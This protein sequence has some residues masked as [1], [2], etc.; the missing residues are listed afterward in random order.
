MWILPD[1]WRAATPSVLCLGSNHF[2]QQSKGLEDGSRSHAGVKATRPGRCSRAGHA[3]AP[4]PWRT[5]KLKLKTRRL[6]RCARFDRLRVP[7]HGGSRRH[8]VGVNF[9][10]ADKCYALLD[11]S[12][13]HISEPT[14]LLSI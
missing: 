6:G 4:M 2:V 1:G 11:L 13:I 12:L 5:A 10:F 14:R 3:Q 8:L 9:G 7:H